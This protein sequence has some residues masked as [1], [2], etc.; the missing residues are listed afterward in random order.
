MLTVVVSTSLGVG[1][2]QCRDDN[3]AGTLRRR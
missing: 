2:V 3:D 1:T